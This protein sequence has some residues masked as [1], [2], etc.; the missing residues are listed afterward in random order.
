[1]HHHHSRSLSLTDYRLL[2][3]ALP[4]RLESNAKVGRA[5]S[6]RHALSISGQ[7]TSA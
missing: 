5:Y 6:L 4:C 3:R 7:I 2:P 1:L